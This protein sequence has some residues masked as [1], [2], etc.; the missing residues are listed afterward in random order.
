[1][2]WLAGVGVAPAQLRF[3]AADLTGPGIR[4]QPLTVT[5]AAAAADGAVP[6]TAT[7]GKLSVPALGWRNVGARFDG[8]LARTAATRW[9][10]DGQLA[11][12]GA[13]GAALNAATLQLALDTE[14]DSLELHLDASGGGRIDL[15]MPLDDPL[16]LQLDLTNV[17]LAWLQGVLADAWPQGKLGKGRLDADVA[18]DQLDDGL[19]SNGRFRLAQ[20]SFDSRDGT[21]AGQSLAGSGTWALRQDTRGTRL[22]LDARLSGGELLLGPLY[23]SLPPRTARL[24]LRADFDR[25]GTRLSNV[26]FDD[27]ADLRFDGGI[28]FKPDGTLTELRLDGV[29]ARFPEAYQHYA[30]AWLATLGYE[31]LHVDGMLTGSLAWQEGGLQRFSLDADGFSLREPL[32]RLGVEGLRGRVDWSRQASRDATQ[33]AWDG[34]TLEHLPF[35]PARSEWRSSDGLLALTDALVLPLLG[36]SVRLQQ[37]QWSPAVTAQSPRL[38]LALAVT[39]VDLEPLCELFGWP[40]FKGSLGGAIPGLAVDGDQIRFDG[41]LSVNVFDGFVD[42]TQLSLT[43]AFGA[44]PQLDAD[45]ALRRLD[46]EPLTKVFDFG[47]ISGRLD[48]DI[49]GLRMLAWKPVAFDATLRAD[50]GGRISQRAINSLSHL[51]GGIGAGLQSTVLKVFKSFGYDR[52]GLGCQLRDD[53]CHMRGIEQAKDTGYVIVDGRGL[54]HIEVIGHQH[55]VDWPTLVARLLAATEGG[56]VRVE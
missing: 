29:R 46:L 23:A 17:P 39:G 49:H 33:L 41:G 9:Q 56:G 6:L 52:I 5:V 8:V 43:H 15:A 31:N 37:L 55:Q 42:V 34:L 7:V 20:G 44:A 32:R 50:A 24:Q 48:G 18:L 53:I 22:D 14:G 26:V 35:G 45:V 21:L 36:G 12:R 51:G 2:L 16:H 28:A 25:A 38:A 27:G 54:P 13:A 3:E 10:L 1:M 30:S 11:L 19:R 40:R 47:S 4:V